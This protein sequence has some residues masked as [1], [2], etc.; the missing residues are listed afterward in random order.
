[1]PE[2]QLLHSLNCSGMQPKA[3]PDLDLGELL[4]EYRG[5][6]TLP[7]R[8]R[9]AIFLPERSNP[10]LNSKGSPDKTPRAS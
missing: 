6:T 1:M 7:I 5:G 2:Q 3:P 9:K 4:R 10:T 8:G